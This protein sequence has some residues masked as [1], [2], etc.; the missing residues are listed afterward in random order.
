MHSRLYSASPWPRSLSCMEVCPPSVTE[1]PDLKPPTN[2]TYKNFSKSKKRD[3][4]SKIPSICSRIIAAFH[5]TGPDANP[6][7]YFENP[8]CTYRLGCASPIDLSLLRQCHLV[9]IVDKHVFVDVLYRL[10]AG[11]NFCTSYS[12]EGRQN[13]RDIAPP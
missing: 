11:N 2:A 13:L 10:F 9:L 4:S 1:L 8:S 5:P 6:S 3:A 12:W 7:R